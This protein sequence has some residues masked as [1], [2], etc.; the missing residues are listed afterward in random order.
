MRRN[1][2]IMMVLVAAL[3]FGAL[4]ALAQ[5]QGPEPAKPSSPAMKGDPGTGNSPSPSGVENGSTAGDPAQA[6]ER[7]AQQATLEALR[8]NQRTE[9]Q[10]PPARKQRRRGSCSG[11]DCVPGVASSVSKYEDGTVFETSPR[12]VNFRSVVQ[13]VESASRPVIVLPEIPTAVRLSASDVNRITCPA[14]DIREVVFSQEKPMTISYSGRDAFLKYKHQKR[15]GG[16]PGYPTQPTEVFV[17]C[18]EA[19]YNIIAVPEQIPSQTLRLSSGTLD[20]IRKNQA[21]FQGMPF[22]KKILTLVRAAYTDDI[23]DSFTIVPASRVLNIFRDVRVSLIRIIAAE[24]E[25]LRVVEYVLSPRKGVKNGR[26]ELDERDFLKAEMTK[27]PLAIALD[28][29]ILREGDTARLIICELNREE[30]LPSPEETTV[31]IDR[32]YQGSQ[33]RAQTPVEKKGSGSPGGE[34]SRGGAVK[35]KKAAGSAGKP[36]GRGY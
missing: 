2:L 24:G 10:T 34:A 6:E 7:R 3:T 12:P 36:Q 23:P 11:A 8:A 18:A 14:G 20:K 29:T 33:P 5:Q 21:F 32:D 35:Q 25:G 22:E 27:N 28:K 4:D 15:S 30:G 19:T 13:A 9:Q 26:I 1:T 16:S 31:R 17:R